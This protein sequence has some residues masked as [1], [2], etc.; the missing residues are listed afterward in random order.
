MTSS[1]INSRRNL[2]LQLSPLQK[3]SYP[4]ISNS[5]IGRPHK[6]IKFYCI[7]TCF[8]GFCIKWKQKQKNGNFF[9]NVVVGTRRPPPSPPTAP[10]TQKYHFFFLTPPLSDSS[11]PFYSAASSDCF[12]LWRNVS[13]LKSLILINT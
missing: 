7:F 9:P 5:Y 10:S 3:R 8:E 11:F 6:L 13:N 12:T 4:Y 2:R 1:Y